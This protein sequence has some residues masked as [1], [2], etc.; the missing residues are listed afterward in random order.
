MNLSINFCGLNLKNPTILA[1]GVMGVTK[2]S[3]K[4]IAQSGAGAVTIKTITREPRS[5]H[6]NPTM[7]QV[8]GGF[9]N[10][11]GYPN[12]GLE[13]AKEEFSVLGDVGAPVIA[14]AVADSSE[15]F[16]FLA[17]QLSEMDFSAIEIVLS[18]PHTPGLGLMAGHGTPEATYEITKAVREKTRKPLIIKLSPSVA[19]IGELAKEAARAGADAINMGNTIGPGMVIDT[20]AKSPVLG[21]KV[22]GMS[23]P[24]IKPITLRCIYDIYQSVKLPIIGTGGITCGLDAVEAF[25]AGATAVGVGTGVFYRELDVFTDICDEISMFM[26]DNNYSSLKEM[27]GAA[28]E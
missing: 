11:M 20:I 19:G 7:V 12:M 28:H 22:G 8:E 3:L 13:S 24:A 15:G 18:C 1:S 2:A 27:V 14:S 26:Q 23:G 16:A 4:R 5:G 9:L 17:Q 21:F 6:K 25:M 10:A